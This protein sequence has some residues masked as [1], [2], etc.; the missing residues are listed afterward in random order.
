MI[1]LGSIQLKQNHTC[2]LQVGNII[3]DW[4]ANCLFVKSPT[5]KCPLVQKCQSLYSGLIDY[6][7][8]LHMYGDNFFTCNLQG[9][10]HYF[11]YTLDL[12]NHVIAAILEKR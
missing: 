11:Q 6:M 4:P 7:K 2:N 8:M 3:E 10:Y 5:A 9:M 1:F 12:S